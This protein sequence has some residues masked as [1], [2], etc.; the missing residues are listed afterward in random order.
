MKLSARQPPG[1]PIRG[2]EPLAESAGYAR[3]YLIKR[4]GKM[5]VGVSDPQ[6]DGQPRGY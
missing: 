2:Y 6:H 4:L 1:H 5:W 3:L